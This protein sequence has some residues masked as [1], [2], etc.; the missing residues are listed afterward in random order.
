M[1]NK[2]YLPL[3]IVAFLCLVGW[4]GYGHH[5]RVLMKMPRRFRTP[6]VMNTL[7]IEAYRLLCLV[8]GEDFKYP[9]LPS[10]EG[11]YIVTKF[12]PSR[13]LTLFGKTIWYTDSIA[14]E[15]VP[16]PTDLEEQ[17]EIVNRVVA[18]TKGPIHYVAIVHA[19]KSVTEYEAK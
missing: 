18:Q 16:S 10:V 2:L 5:I 7:T 13:R 3:V 4:T 14:L 1:K 11:Q 17:R 19:K 12:I 9:V 8:K 15:Y 6:Y